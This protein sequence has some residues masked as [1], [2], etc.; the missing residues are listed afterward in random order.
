MHYVLGDFGPARECLREAVALAAADRPLH[1]R[2][3]T[4]SLPGVRAPTWLA[5][6]ESE[7]G[8]FPE[9]IELAEEAVRMA[10]SANRPFSLSAALGALGHVRLRRGDLDQA[11]SALEEGLEVSRTWNIINQYQIDAA[12]G[13]VRTLTGRHPEALALLEDAVRQG[14]ARGPRALQALRLAWLGEAHLHAGRVDEAR[15]RATEALDFAVTHEER[16]SQA[17]TLRLLAEIA[18]HPTASGA[19]EAQGYYRQAL[20]LAGQLEMRPLTA[21]CHLGLGK[22][23]RRTGDTAK[24]KEHLTA[25]TTMYREMGMGFWL[26][27]AETALGGVEQ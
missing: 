17:W 14:S 19:E 20:E 23:Y 9:A 3:G 1:L 5:Q 11:A 2:R 10:R 21:H 16:V 12:L 22:L 8:S 6:T 27:K 13:H 25:A 15:S 24:A 18:M 26:E 7:T 4:T